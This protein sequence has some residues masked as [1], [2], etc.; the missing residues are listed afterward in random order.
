MGR[1]PGFFNGE[2]LKNM[3]DK[4]LSIGNIGSYF[5]SNLDRKEAAPVETALVNNEKS[6]SPESDE[7]KLRDMIRSM[8]E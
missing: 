5:T 1:E 8:R 6:L 7:G 4:E 3:L 2:R